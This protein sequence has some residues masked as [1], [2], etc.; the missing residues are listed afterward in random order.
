MKPNVRGHF[1]G[2]AVVIALASALPL[3]PQESLQQVYAEAKQAQQNGDLAT[4]ALK[5]Q[6]IVKLQPKMAEAYANLG[7][8]YYQQ[9]KM[10]RASDAY[11]TALKL[12][13]ELAG[14]HFFLGV[15]AFGVHDYASA[16]PHLQKAAA[17]QADNPTV[18]AYLGYTFYAR[19]NFHE[20][21]AEL[22]RAAALDASDIDVLY[23]LSKSYTHLADEAYG[24]LRD[25]FG[26]SVYASLARAHAYEA[27]ENWKEAHEQYGIAQQL[28]PANE[29]L[30]AK[31]EWSAAK[32]AG[33]AASSSV[34]GTTDSPDPIIDASLAYRDTKLSGAALKEQIARWQSTVHALD[35]EVSLTAEGVSRS[36]RLS[37]RPLPPR[38]L[39]SMP[40]PI[41]IAR[42][43]CRPSFSKLPI[44]MSRPS[45]ST[46]TR[47]NASRNY[48]TFTSPLDRCTG[49]INRSMP[50]ARNCWMN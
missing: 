28:L 27:Q 11:R 14:P 37:D 41:R 24:V 40:V 48:K 35:K 32:A 23:H 21:A 6:E 25:R 45:P 31:V 49:K 1:P 20:A 42:M 47:L 36:C 8:I 29:R 50:R 46:A 39:Y 17:L 38:W 26:D 15:I 44:R 4:A 5:Y 12:K 19:S 30:K 33:G 7:N 13:P 2:L 22:E 10:D 43:S 9:A 34:S 3:F 16:L 18:H